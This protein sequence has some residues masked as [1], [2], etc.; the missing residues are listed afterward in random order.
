MGEETKMRYEKTLPISLIGMGASGLE[1]SLLKDS[2][3]FYLAAGFGMYTFGVALKYI[4]DKLN[5]IRK[6]Y[7]KF[8]EEY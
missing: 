1:A 5:Y 7:W 8:K 3:G 4:H 6:N 2:F